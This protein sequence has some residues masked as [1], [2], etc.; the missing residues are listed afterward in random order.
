MKLSG[1]HLSNVLRCLK[2]VSDQVGS[3]VGMLSAP[4]MNLPVSAS[5]A[6]S[7]CAVWRSRRSIPEQRTFEETLLAYINIQR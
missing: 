6:H 5:R 2:I 7:M 1:N 3:L 4:S